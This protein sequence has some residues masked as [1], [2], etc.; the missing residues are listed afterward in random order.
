MIFRYVPPMAGGLEYRAKDGKETSLA[1]LSGFAANC[2]D[3]WEFTLDTLGRYYERVGSL[4]E[5]QRAAPKIEGQPLDAIEAELPVMVTERLGTYVEAARLLGERTAAMHLC[6]ASDKD[7]KDFA[8]EPFNP[9]YQRSLFQSMRNMAV[10]NLGLLQARIE[11]RAGG[12][13]RR[14]GKSGRLAAGNSETAAR[15]WPT[16]ASPACGC[17]CMAIIISAR[18]CTPARIF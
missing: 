17:A 1:I 13:S 5:E 7:D 2:K 9:F 6:L 8:P 14:G 16:C 15:R 12:G 11:N 3:A 4:P 18:C 10:E